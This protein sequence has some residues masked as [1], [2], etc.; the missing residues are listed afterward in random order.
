MEK[1]FI[2]TSIV[3]DLL[4]QRDEFYEAAQELFSKSDNGEIE[5]M[6]LH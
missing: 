3:I 6:F 2:D 4:A 1:I 5:L